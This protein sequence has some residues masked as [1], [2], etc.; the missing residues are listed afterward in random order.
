MTTPSGGLRMAPGT[1]SISTIRWLT[2]TTSLERYSSDR[3]ATFLYQPTTTETARWSWASGEPRIGCG[4]RERSTRY[5]RGNK[6]LEHQAT[7]RCLATTSERARLIT[8]FFGPPRANGIGATLQPARL[9]AK[10]GGKPG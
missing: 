1:F 2:R 3:L 9:E 4:S 10:P 8:R 6:V 5:R 7:F